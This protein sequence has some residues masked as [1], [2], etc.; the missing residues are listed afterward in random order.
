MFDAQ[1]QS[2]SVIASWRGVLTGGDDGALDGGLVSL[3]VSEV[4][5]VRLQRI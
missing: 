2:L 4:F 1:H 3:R 5:D